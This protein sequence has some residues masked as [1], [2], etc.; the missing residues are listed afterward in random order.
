MDK[1]KITC[2]CR[3]LGDINR[4]N[5]IQT[6][7]GDEK[8]ACYILEEFDITQPTLSHHM[9]VLCESGLVVSR[10]EGRWHYYRLNRETL[11]EFGKFIADLS[12]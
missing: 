10:K 11:D 8:C 9:K 2:I 4:L 7:T 12:K 3:A 1:Q 6:L 5:I